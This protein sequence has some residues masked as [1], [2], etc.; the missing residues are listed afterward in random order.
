[1]LSGEIEPPVDRD[2]AQGAHVA[3]EEI[4]AEQ[5]HGA[6]ERTAVEI[7]LERAHDCD[8]LV[9]RIDARTACLDEGGDAVIDADAVGIGEAERAV[10]VDVNVD[11]AGRQ[12]VAG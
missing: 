9:E 12:V 7:G 8:E 3:L 4:E 5:A 10:G 6:D 1:M 2:V 11:P